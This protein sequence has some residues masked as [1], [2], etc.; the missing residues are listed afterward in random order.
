MAAPSK[1]FQAQDSEGKDWLSDNLAS[2]DCL[3][4]D[5]YQEVAD[6]GKRRFSP[7]DWVWEKF[8]HFN[9]EKNAQTLNLTGQEFNIDPNILLAFF[10]YRI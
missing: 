6:L 3:N 10:N 8:P 9:L 1:F 7:P 5:F 2:H 4:P